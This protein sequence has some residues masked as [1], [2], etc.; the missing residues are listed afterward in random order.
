MRRLGSSA[1][2]VTE[3]CLGTMTFGVQNSEADAHE[4]LDYA[5]KTRGVNFVDTA[6]LYPVAFNYGKTTE[7]WIGNWL[8]SREA[9]GT[10]KRSDLYLATKCNGSRIGGFPDSETRPDNFCYSFAD[11]DIVAP[12]AAD[13]PIYDSVAD[14]T[15]VRTPASITN[16]KLVGVVGIFVMEYSA[17]APLFA[18]PVGGASP[19]VRCLA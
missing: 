14:A 8:A 1:L 11:A 12:A 7:K 17:A 6:E 10:V 18:L 13:P 4:Q 9:K 15:G 2:E 3:A 16:E 19:Q 5:I